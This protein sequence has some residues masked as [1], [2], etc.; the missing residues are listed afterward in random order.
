MSKVLNW[1]FGHTQHPLICEELTS[2][3]NFIQKVT[4]IHK[5]VKSLFILLKDNKDIY[6]TPLLLLLY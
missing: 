4:N 1:Q 6:I 3:N 5:I 2:Y